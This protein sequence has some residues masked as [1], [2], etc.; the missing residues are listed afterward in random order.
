MTRLAKRFTKG[1]NDNTTTV[2]DTDTG[3]EREGS[4]H[5]YIEK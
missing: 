3:V 5:P 4:G 2:E 1:D